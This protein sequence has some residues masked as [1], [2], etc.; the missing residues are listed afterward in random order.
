MRIAIVDYGMGNLASVRFACDMLELP[1]NVTDQPEG[2]RT[3]TGVVLPGV[4][5][6]GEAMAA[7]ERTGLGAAVVD[8]ACEGI[9]VLGV[10][11]GMQLLMTESYEFGHHRGLGLVEG[12]V[13]PLAA[14][15]ES[16]R[17]C[18]TPHLGWAPIEPVAGASW[19]HTPLEAIA[20]G[21][22]MA[23]AHSFVVSPADPAVAL[24]STPFGAGG[25]CSS[26]AVGNLF[27]C[28]FH[29]ERSGSPGLDLY[30]AAFAPMAAAAPW[31]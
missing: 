20:P 23:F 16:G 5:A 30:R 1:S 25:F 21:T 18:K 4:G 10:C 13:L 15:D 12:V 14:L 17:A 19:Q 28:Q 27:G 11:L 9:P 26:L 7:L 8:A 2:V 24:S 29:P 31:G 3:A 6:F 22:Y